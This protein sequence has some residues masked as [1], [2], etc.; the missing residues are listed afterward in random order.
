MSST[1]TRRFALIALA[2]VLLVAGLLLALHFSP[3]SDLSAR[4]ELLQFVPSETTSV[5]FLDL[6]QFRDSPFLAKI[7]SWA[8]HPAED[9]EYA[10]FVRDTG[11]SYERDLKR[12]VI[13]IS[14][15][16]TTTNFLTV[17]DGEFDRKK[18]ESFLNRN[19]QAAQQGKWKVYLLNQ[20]AGGR[21]LSLVFLSDSRVAIG[22]SVQFSALL[23]PV[24]SHAFRAAGP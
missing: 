9:S 22:D 7:Y 16:D 5:I 2:A 24:P 21:R 18:I 13:A 8:P 17:A 23:R 11:F 1:N 6:D 20:N 12:V 3:R 4:R 10:Q 19:A 14:N 15:R